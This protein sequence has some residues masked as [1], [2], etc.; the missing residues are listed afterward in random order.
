MD[1]HL[2][3]FNKDKKLV[4][5]DCETLNLCLNFCSNLP[6]QIA[7]MK[8][9]GD[10][11]EGFKNFYIKWNTNLKI[12]DEA[13]RITRYSQSTI[14]K[15]GISP[16]EAFPTIYDWLENCDYILGHNTLG[17]DIYLIK[18]YYAMMGKSSKHLV[19]K[20]IDTHCLAKGVKLNLP[21]K[22]SECLIEYQYKMLHTFKKG[23]KTNLTAM[24]KEYEIDHDYDNL[25]DA[26]VDLSLNLK[27]W[28]KLKWQ[29][30]I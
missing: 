9:S 27:V 12:S 19:N 11:Q 7:M 30:E 29:V 2:L 17:F 28:N 4:F 20:F 25:H 14:D 18:E 13:A 26:I 10:H 5:I 21:Y 1:E 24:G 3:R 16:E 8:V 23:V 6:W 15:L 22:Q